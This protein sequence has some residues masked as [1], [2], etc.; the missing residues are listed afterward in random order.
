ML[1][2][3]GVALR[4]DPSALRYLEYRGKTSPVDPRYAAALEC[5]SS[6]TGKDRPQLV[7]ESPA[8]TDCQGL[9]RSSRP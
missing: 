9:A 1:S 6:Q 5:R 2:K 3:A 8:T 7:E 4:Y